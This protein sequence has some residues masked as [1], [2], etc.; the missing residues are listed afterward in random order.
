[1]ITRVPGRRIASA[2]KSAYGC[3]GYGS[4]PDLGYGY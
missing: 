3:G 1:M 4:A 2:W